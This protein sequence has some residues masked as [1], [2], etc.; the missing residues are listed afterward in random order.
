MESCFPGG[1]HG[2][3]ARKEVAGRLRGLPWGTQ[4]L[5]PPSRDH[6]TDQP[7]A[8]LASMYPAPCTAQ[9]PKSGSAGSALPSRGSQ[10]TVSV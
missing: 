6:G 9:G 5:N 10:H 3:S 2:G 4:R 8:S 7:M 1:N